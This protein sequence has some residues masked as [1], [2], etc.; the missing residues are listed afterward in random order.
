MSANLLSLEPSSEIR[1]SCDV[2]GHRHRLTWV[3]SIKCVAKCV[4][5]KSEMFIAAGTVI[6]LSLIALG[7]LTKAMVAS[8]KKNLKIATAFEC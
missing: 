7:W 5:R 4:K 6:A 2:G 3:P 8:K 1:G